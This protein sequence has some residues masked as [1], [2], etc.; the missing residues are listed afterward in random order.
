[1]EAVGRLT[2][3]VAH[4][5]NN[6]LAAILGS[7]ELVL[8][9]EKNPRSLKLLRTAFEAA[10]RGARL[11]AQMLSFSR[12]SEVSVRSVD[13]NG[14]ILGM[15]DL[16]R[17]SLGPVVH[18]RY[19]LASDAGPVLADPGQLELALLN[20][21]VNARD[22]MPNGGD[23]TIRT[24]IDPDRDSGAFVRVSVIDTG[25]GMTEEVRS[26]A[27]EPFFTTKGPGLGTGLGLS[28]VYGFVT[29]VGGTLTIDTTPGEG[30]TISVFLRRADRAPA[31][32]GLAEAAAA[33]PGQPGRVLLVDDDASVR[34]STR[35]MLEE[36][37]HTVVDVGSGAE[38]LAVLMDDRRFDLVLVD[39]AMPVMNGS[40]VAAEVTRLWPGA[41]LLFMTGY[42]EN[43][44]LRPWS[45]L[46]YRTL[47][48]PFSANGLAAAVQAS[49]RRDGFGQKEVVAA[50]PPGVRVA[51]GGTVFSQEDESERLR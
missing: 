10:Q 20:L 33:A 15:E 26:R 19:D 24:A 3:G 39:F 21:A 41:P 37:G 36:Q 25:Q 1:M 18:L 13:V 38:A 5:F 42:V 50:A 32:E 48:K 43:D 9:Q 35:T 31:V 40:Q 29:E 34:M 47:G 16:L 28:M 14:I 8:R 6:L 45:D 11:T 4:D 23:L 12:K 44:G 30:T 51:A 27:L 7:L 22:A 49:T 46:G 17:R 2:G